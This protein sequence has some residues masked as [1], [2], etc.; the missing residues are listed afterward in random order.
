MEKGVLRAVCQKYYKPLYLYALSLC[1]HPSDAED[2][3]Q[4]TFLKET[5][6]RTA[7]AV[8]NWF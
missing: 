1:G 3:V 7:E 5:V 8:V 4:S 2:L 6:A